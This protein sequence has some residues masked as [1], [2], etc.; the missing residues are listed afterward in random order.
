M[1]RFKFFCD[2]ILAKW[3]TG[4][5]FPSDDSLG[6]RVGNSFCSRPNP[7]LDPIIDYLLNLPR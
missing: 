4:R 5:K 6:K 3:S 7:H 2:T 1:A